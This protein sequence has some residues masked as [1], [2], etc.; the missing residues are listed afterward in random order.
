M[1][2]VDNFG[3]I[4]NILSL[5]D[6]FLWLLPRTQVKELVKVLQMAKTGAEKVVDMGLD[7]VGIKEELQRSALND[8]L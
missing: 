8:F 1:S 4:I 5:I 6:V 3:L 7:V 2:P